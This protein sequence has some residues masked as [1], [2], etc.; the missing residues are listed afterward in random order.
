MDSMSANT[1]RSLGI[2]LPNAKRIYERRCQARDDDGDEHADRKTL[3]TDET[4]SEEQREPSKKQ[5]IH[6]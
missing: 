4:L 2:A 3:A 5:T 6:G 1:I